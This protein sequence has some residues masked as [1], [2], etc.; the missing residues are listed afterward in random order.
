KYYGINDLKYVNSID[1]INVKIDHSNEKISFSFVIKKDILNNIFK[2]NNDEENL[3]DKNI[4]IINKF[5]DK[6]LNKFH[7]RIY[8]IM[9]S[10]KQIHEKKLDALLELESKQGNKISDRTK[11][12]ITQI[13]NSILE[14]SDFTMQNNN[15][16]IVN[17]YRK[18]FRKLHLN[19]NEYV[20]SILLLLFLGNILIRNFDKI[21]K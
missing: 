2:N 16:I 10:Q 14:I 17:D 3:N 12:E 11:M 6:S 1:K 5:I 4:E 21:L 19:T 13:K 15:L 18:K 7:T 8:E 9:I 20:L